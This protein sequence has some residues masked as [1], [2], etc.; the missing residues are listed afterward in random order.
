MNADPPAR[1]SAPAAPPPGLGRALRWAAG[2]AL[3]F[4]A[5]ALALTVWQ[6]EALGAA[7]ARL[8]AATLGAAAGLC[9]LN[10][11]LRGA[12]WI[13]WVRADGL[14]LPAGRGLQLYLAAYAGT[15]T[16]GNV[17]EALRGAWLRPQAPAW[18]LGVFAAERLADLIALLALAALAAPAWAPALGAGLHRAAQAALEAPALAAGLVLAVLAALMGARRWA[19]RQAPEPAGGWRAALAQAKGTVAACLRHRPLAWL[20]ASM[21]AWAAQGVAVALLAAGLGRPLGW[22]EASGAYAAAMVAGAASALPAGLGSMEA[23]F[24]ALM[25]AAG[26]PLAEALTL[27]LLVRALT[28]WQA[29]L[30][31]LLAWASLPRARMPAGPAAPG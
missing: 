5:Q 21:L 23:S 13:A 12:R 30:I 25:L 26:W 16:P 8:D 31:G 2:L 20:G 11:L 9:L 15:A 24:T 22:V 28:L 1:E 19:R 27:M 29:L 14:S 7:L 17:G 10:Y 18:S 6:A 3:L 4:A